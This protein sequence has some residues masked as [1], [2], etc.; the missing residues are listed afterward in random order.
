MY[1]PIASTLGSYLREDEYEMSRRERIHEM[2]H[3]LLSD[4]E[5]QQLLE[6]E[7]PE[8]DK[9][10]RALVHSVLN[11]KIMASL[12]VAESEL[13]A[14]YLIAAHKQAAK[15]LEQERRQAQEDAV[16]RAYEYHWRAA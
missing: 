3:E 11:A 10:R 5:G 4:E 1:C 15:L 9:A 13:K 16:I 12:T 2:A 8:I 6:E 7:Y 14:A